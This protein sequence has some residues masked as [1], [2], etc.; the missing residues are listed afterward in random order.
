MAKSREVVKFFTAYG[1]IDKGSTSYD[2]YEHTNGRRTVIGRDPEILNQ[3]FENMKKQ[4][5]LK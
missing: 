5:G 4:A 3:L 1:F 2:R